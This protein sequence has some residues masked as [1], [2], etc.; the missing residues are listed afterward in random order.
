MTDNMKFMV[1]LI[2][3]YWWYEAGKLE[4]MTEDE[5]RDIYNR[6]LDWIGEGGRA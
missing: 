3:A 1:H 6:L 4:A 2:R 5:V